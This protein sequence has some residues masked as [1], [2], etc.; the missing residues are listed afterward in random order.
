MTD[1]R[2]RDIFFAVMVILWLL[3]SG[4]GKEVL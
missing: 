3:T 2:I 4:L 1:E